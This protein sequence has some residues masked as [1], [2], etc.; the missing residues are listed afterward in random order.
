MSSHDKKLVNALHSESAMFKIIRQDN[1]N[2]LLKL[3]SF[4]N[5]Q[6]C[7][8]NSQS[9]WEPIYNSDFTISFKSE[10]NKYLAVL[11]ING[12]LS[13]R[14]NDNLNP[15]CKWEIIP[16]N[17]T[18][19]GNT[20]SENFT[21][22]NQGYEAI[23]TI[24]TTY[25]GQYP[26]N[27][28]DNINYFICYNLQSDTS[29]FSKL[30]TINYLKDINSSVTQSWTQPLSVCSVEKEYSKSLEQT[31]SISI[32]GNSSEVIIVNDNMINIDK[33]G[34]VNYRNVSDI[35]SNDTSW[36]AFTI[37]N[38]K[39]FKN[40]TIGKFNG[41]LVVMAISNN[42]LCIREFDKFLDGVGWVVTNYNN[43]EQV[44][45]NFIDEKLYAIDSVSKNL[46]ILGSNIKYENINLKYFKFIYQGNTY[47]LYGINSNNILVY[48]DL[49]KSSQKIL[50]TTEILKFDIHN[51][52]IYAITKNTQTLVYKPIIYESFIQYDNTNIIDVNIYNDQ[53]YAVKSDGNLLTAP[54]LTKY[55]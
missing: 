26:V 52:I 11:I 9:N 21:S 28:Q 29:N 43:V 19:I 45:Y 30:F 18:Y 2:N 40:L 7:E 41:Q 54:I 5:Q 14:L 36:R 32:Y 27:I 10:S 55:F 51:N 4:S 17:T 8:I 13:I 50:D 31:F 6:N 38:T 47:S 37:I 1:N 44:Q 53:I 3:F 46:I 42:T 15:S 39:T 34:L 23:T 33:N 16:I 35:N 24:D 22:S 49:S 48:I 12:I 25:I 20:D